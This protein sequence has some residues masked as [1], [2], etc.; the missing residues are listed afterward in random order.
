MPVQKINFKAEFDINEAQL[1]KEALLAQLGAAHNF[2]ELLKADAH[3]EY[4]NSL[5][6]TEDKASRL[7]N[8]LIRFGANVDEMSQAVFDRG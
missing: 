4:T 3:G 6:A 8:L 1:I 2:I 7:S 5:K